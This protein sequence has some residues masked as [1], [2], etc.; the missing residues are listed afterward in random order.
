MSIVLGVDPATRNWGMVLLDTSTDTIIDM[1]T[2][3]QEQSFNKAKYSKSSRY[4]DIGRKITEVFREWCS[5]STVCFSELPTGSQS[6]RAA[7]C[8]GICLGVLSGC[9]IPLVGSTPIQ[10]KKVF[11]GDRSASKHKMI[12]RAEELYPDANWNRHKKT[13]VIMRKDEHKA[14][15]IAAIHAGLANMLPSERKRLGL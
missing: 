12:D 1:I 15:A 11:T 9:P 13:G 6:S 4:L 7:V 14:D 8:S 10:V 5:R 3:R 2:V